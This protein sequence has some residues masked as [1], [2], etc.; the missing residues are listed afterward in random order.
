MNSIFNLILTASLLVV[1][2]VSG[3]MMGPDY[4]RPEN[5]AETAERF[6]N[7]SNAISDPNTIE[8]IG[9]WWQRFGDPTL[10]KLVLQA[11]AN[12]NDIKAAAARV[13]AY[14]AILDETRGKEL[15]EVSYGI[16]RSRSKT[17]TISPL[18]DQAPYL[19][20][21]WSH[22]ISVS[23]VVDLFGKL[24]RSE[25]A[26]YR[27]LLASQ[28][29]R[30]ALIHTI[31]AQ[32]VRART[33]IATIQRH[34]AITREN[35]ADWQTSLDLI[36]RRYMQGIVD[37]LDVRMARENL[38]SVKVNENVLEQTLML[39]QNALDVLLGQQPGGSPLLPETLGDL[40]SPEPIPVGIPAMLLD[41]RPDLVQAE[42]KLASATSVVGI[43]IAQLYPDLTLTARYGFV[44]D[45]FIDIAA[46]KGEVYSA[47]IALVQPIFRGGQLKARV[48]E[49]KA[50]VTQAA[51]NYAGAVLI[52]MRQVEDALLQE[53]ML[54][55][56]LELLQARLAEAQAAENI[57]NRQYEQGL[58]GLLVVLETQRRRQVAETELA[59]TK[60]TIWT[61][62]VDLFLAIG[63]DWGDYDQAHSETKKKNFNR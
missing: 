26:S 3:C 40:P 18:S 15:P 7:D 62:R 12:N 49:A 36:E 59:I 19:S 25:E 35:V 1:V 34:L 37:A 8:A 55:K 14:Q 31:I 28:A 45:R 16:S 57:A 27:D 54:R 32:V 6:F 5:T 58:K 29:D 63:G 53:Q 48:A 41:R 46:S 51:A 21:S 33:Q 47:V 4:H 42:M 22:D 61:N 39:T 2:F 60:G 56:R 13:L 30:Q 20:T 24:R 38:A 10:D 52:A 43:R 11:L 23:Y 50:Q 17:A 44:T 9:P